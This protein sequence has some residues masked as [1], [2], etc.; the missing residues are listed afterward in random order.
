M[1]DYGVGLHESM[2][3]ALNI[4][5]RELAEIK[6][7]YLAGTPEQITIWKKYFGD[8]FNYVMVDELVAS[9]R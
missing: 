4:I 1:G 9:E 5:E 6:K 3:Q 7:P 8:Q 2:K